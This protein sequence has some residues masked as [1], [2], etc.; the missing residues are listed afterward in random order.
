M[1]TRNLPAR[2]AD[3][4]RAQILEAQSLDYVKWLSCLATTKV[5]DSASE[6]F[7]A[8]YPN[9]LGASAVRKSL[10]TLELKSATPP[11]STSGAD[12]GKPLI[13]VQSLASGFAQI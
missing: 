6:L 9:S 5:P 10:D 3:V 11:G 1:D 8:R 13:G 2:L 4:T 7:L 12:W